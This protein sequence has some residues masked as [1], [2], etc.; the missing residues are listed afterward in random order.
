MR[1]RIVVAI[2]AVAAA[3]IVLL[4]V[5]LAISLRNEL[6]DE[7]LL[8]LDRDTIAATREVDLHA[9]SRDHVEFPRSPD[10]TAVYDRAG[11]RVAGSGAPRADAAVRAALRTGKPASAETGGWL[12]V[13]VPI[14]AR[15]RVAGVLRAAR[16][17]ASLDAQVRNRLL[18]IAAIGLGVTLVA[19]LAA[20]AVARRLTR[21][22]ERLAGTAERLGE[23]DFSARAPRA[24]VPEL[25]AVAAT[26]DATAERL[27]ALLARERAFSADASHQ[28]RTPLAALRLELE[29]LALDERGGAEEVGRALEQVDRLE[30]T[31]DTLLALARDAP[32]ERSEIDLVATVDLL[33]ESWRG[34]LAAEGRP[35]RVVSASPHTS[36]RAAPA[37]VEQVLDVLLD[38]ARRHGAGEVT[39]TVRQAQGGVAVDVADRGQGLEGDPEAAFARRAGTGNGHGIGLALARSLAHADSGRLV[40]SRAGPGPVFTLLLPAAAAPQR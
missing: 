13:A 35:L 22:L 20:L 40:V 39:V 18:L 27:G 26:L 32:R 15:E 6:R 28:L 3:S 2:V 24:G 37:V 30:G 29:S 10:Q 21:P 4:A 34:R 19:A 38:N 5:P 8:R 11:Q 7:A 1:R 14:L 33:A 36:A 23:G 25:D 9:R 31:I 16:S 17:T 12:I